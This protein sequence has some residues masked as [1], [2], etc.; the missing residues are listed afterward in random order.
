MRPF[1]LSITGDLFDVSGQPVGDLA[2]DVVK[3]AD[4]LKWSLIPDHQPRKGDITYKERLYS[5]EITAGHVRSADG[6]VICRPW[7]KAAALGPN[8]DRLVV[9]GRAGIGYDKLDL[10]ACTAADVVVFNSP[11]G[12]THSTASAAMLFILA[13]SKKLPLQERIVRTGAWD[14]QAAALG[15]DLIDQT[16]GIVGFGHT[17][18]ELVR[19]LAPYGMRVIAFSP[20]ADLAVAAK[21][22]VILTATIDE[23]FKKSDYIS[24]H[25]RLTEQTRHS[26]GERLL[27]MMKPTAYFINVSRGEIVEEEALIR[28]LAEHRIAGAG[29]DVFEEEPLPLSSPFLQMDNVMLTPHWLCSTRQAGRATMVG[30]MDGILRVS[31]GEIPEN[32]LNPDVLQRPGFRAKLARFDENRQ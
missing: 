5:M 7:L 3:S 24:L 10:K 12:L 23:I 8:A 29:L 31:R 28:S 30:V 1:Q 13:L 6:I 26:I 2:L 20:H 16:L 15:N 21:M 17:A 4:Y 22:G 9:I 18:I 32:I 14:Q 19:L 25:N 11:Y 27:H